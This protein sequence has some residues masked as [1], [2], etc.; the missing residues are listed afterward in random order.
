M[1]KTIKTLVMVLTTVTLTAMAPAVEEPQPNPAAT[2]DGARQVLDEA[3]AQALITRVQQSFLAFNQQAELGLVLRT[4]PWF[5]N[6]RWRAHRHEGV[7][8]VVFEGVIDD[9]KAVKDFYERNK[10]AWPESF[11]AMQLK[12][13]Y[14]LS[15]D[16]KALMFRLF[17][18]F[19]DA[20]SFVPAGG[21]LGVQ[22][23]S[24]DVWQFQ[25]LDHKTFTA[26]VEGIYGRIDPYLIL[27]YGLPY[28]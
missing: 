20:R 18:D 7:Q 13:A 4:Y 9:A 22:R 23:A 16:K 12:T 25:T 14:S 19:S 8:R 5:Q 17:F 11:K 21:E 26:V 2:S 10:Y 28:K 15:E 3:T 24:D 1:N 27:V 6:K